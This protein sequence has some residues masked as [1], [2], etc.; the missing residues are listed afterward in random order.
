MAV[1]PPPPAP[2]EQTNSQPAATAEER[3]A[4]IFTVQRD[5][6]AVQPPPPEPEDTADVDQTS[7]EL[8][9]D[10]PDA[11]GAP[12][13]S[14]ED[15]FEFELDGTTYAL[16]KTLE[17]AVQNQ[18][19][20]TQ[21]TQ[22]LAEQRKTSE[23]VMKRMQAD[24]MRSQFNAENAAELQQLAAIDQVLSQQVDW[25]SMSTDDLVRTG[26]QREQWKEQREAIARSLGAK[27]QQFE[28]ARERAYAD[29]RVKAQ[30][31]TA[32]RVPGWND[33]VKKAVR[34]HALAEGITEAELAQAELDPRHNVILWQ[35]QQYALLKANAK[36]T[37]TGV[38]S[39]KTTSST[40]MPP[41]VKAKLNFRK[42]L[43]KA[44]PGS[45]ERKAL[46]EQRAASIFAKSR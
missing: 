2:K 34:E 32:Q 25:N 15:I 19:D 38:K 46:V 17:K 28:A 5:Q 29:L 1:Q 24:A 22:S 21:K 18:R 31:L 7:A 11:G 27:L 30:E 14:A 41:Q 44:P 36:K 13:A 9:D 20:Y 6:P 35:A 3:A 39:I 42:A 45:P 40:P 16:P 8:P 12:D 37:V 33:A 10:A 26:R 23:H 43:S 4:R